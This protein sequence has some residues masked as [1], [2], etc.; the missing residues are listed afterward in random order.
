MAKSAIGRT[1]VNRAIAIVLVL[2][3]VS[4]AV[5]LLIYLI[6]SR[7]VHWRESSMIAGG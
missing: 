4:F 1:A 3:V 6:E 7:V 2:G 5:I